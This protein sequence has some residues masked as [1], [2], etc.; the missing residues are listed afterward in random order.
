M[1]EIMGQYVD[2]KEIDGQEDRLPKMLGEDEATG[3]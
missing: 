3:S 1:R 2:E